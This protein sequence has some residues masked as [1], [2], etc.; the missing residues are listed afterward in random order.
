MSPSTS[1]GLD[2]SGKDV[3][4]NNWITT[5]F[6]HSRPN[7]MFNV[8]K[9]VRFHSTPKESYLTTI[10][11]IIWYLIRTQDIGLWYPCSS[12]FNLIGYS[13]ADFVGDK[14]DRKNTSGTRQI[15][16]DALILWHINKKTSIV[17]ST[18][19]AKYIVVGSCGTPI[20]WIMHQ[21]LNFNVFWICSHNVW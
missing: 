15:F 6:D 5:L 16:G 9:C 18:S 21:L 19:D 17:L 12:Y 10:K 11:R 13:N 1:I 4:G 14:S 8:C 2:S 20:L 3:Q 7:I